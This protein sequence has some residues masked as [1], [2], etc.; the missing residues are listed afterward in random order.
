VKNICAL[1]AFPIVFYCILFAASSALAFSSNLRLVPLNPGASAGEKREYAL[2]AQGLEGLGSVEVTL[3]YPPGSS[4]NVEVVFDDALQSGSSTAMA[5]KSS[6][7]SVRIGVINAN[8][9]S[10]LSGELASI[11]FDNVQKSEHPFHISGSAIVTDLDGKKVNSNIVIE[12]ANDELVE[13]MEAGELVDS[14]NP[15]GNYALGISTKSQTLTYPQPY[16]SNNNRSGQTASQGKGEINTALAK[17]NTSTETYKPENYRKEPDN[18]HSPN[19]SIVSD[20]KDKSHKTSKS[21]PVAYKLAEDGEKSG[22]YLLIID[23]PRGKFNFIL[24]NGQVTHLSEMD[25][26]VNLKIIADNDCALYVFTDTIL[27]ISLDKHN[28]KT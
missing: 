8:G 9:F 20:I 16:R 22:I 25:K 23:L 1:K 6:P 28:K 26:K 2:L 3:L 17:K 11:S 10:S 15:A 4:G 14:A 12:Q 13:K 18:A 7:G 27:R 21:K 19:K 24:V 5:N